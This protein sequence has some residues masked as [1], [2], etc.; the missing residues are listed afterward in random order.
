MS[1]THHRIDMAY[2]IRDRKNE[3]RLVHAAQPPKRTPHRIRPWIDRIES[4]ERVK[5]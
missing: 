5:H 1:T 4:A 2:E 3:A